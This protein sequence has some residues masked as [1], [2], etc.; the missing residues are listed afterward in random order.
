MVNIR[1]YIPGGFPSSPVVVSPLLFIAQ[2]EGLGH[3]LV[4]TNLRSSGALAPSRRAAA[5]DAGI[6]PRPSIPPQRG[7]MVFLQVLLSVGRVG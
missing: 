7:A 3:L 2:L 5:G 6:R 1:L 4:C